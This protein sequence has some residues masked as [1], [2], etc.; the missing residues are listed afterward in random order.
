MITGNFELQTEVGRRRASAN[1]GTLTPILCCRLLPSSHMIFRMNDAAI[2]KPG[3]LPP[4]ILAQQNETN[5]ATI[6]ARSSVSEIA[7]SPENEA[8]KAKTSAKDLW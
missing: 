1:M 3:K 5:P 6:E 7:L 8:T 4:I 2:M